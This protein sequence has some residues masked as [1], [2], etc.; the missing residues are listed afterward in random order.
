MTRAEV[1]RRFDEILGFAEVASFI[2]TPVKFYSSGMFV[3]LGFAVAVLAEPDVLLV[4]EVLAVGD[5]AFQLKCYERMK[6]IRESGTTI[7]VVSHN[8]NS[9]RNLC[10]RSIVVHDGTVRLDGSTADAISLYHDLLGEER[11]P[12]ETG[13]VAPHERFDICAEITDLEL[14]GPEGLPVAH[15]ES[16]DE[17][18]LRAGVRFDR[19]V[20]RPVLGL[21]ITSEAGV[22]VYGKV[23]WD[24]D[25]SFAAGSNARIEARL[26]PMLSTGSYA[27]QLGLRSHDATAALSRPGR[28]LLFYVLGRTGVTGLADLDASVTVRPSI[29][30]A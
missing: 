12:N 25:A 19:P 5:L 26:K 28:P 17:I 13:F 21:R 1:D 27:V 14:I 22:L 15:V 3:R 6:E 9:I 23:V 8:L 2:D 4:D 10:E 16:Q 20:D 24:T 29:A 7:V 11:D 30:D 18:L